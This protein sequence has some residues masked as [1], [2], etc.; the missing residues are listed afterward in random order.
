MNPSNLVATLVALLASASLA[1]AAPPADWLIEPAPFKARVTKSQDGRDLE[2]NNGLPCHSKWITVSN[3]TDQAV[4]VDRFSSEVLAVV[5]HTAEVEELSEGR[6][7]PHLYIETDMAFGGMMAAGANRRSFR[8]LADP[9]FHTQVNYEKKTP[10]LLDVG[11]D[12]G[13]AQ[14][15]APGG[16]FESFSI[17]NAPGRWSS[18][19]SI[20][21]R[22]TATSWKAISSTTAGPTRA[23]STGC[24]T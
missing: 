23:T 18:R 8:W 9:D 1:S 12:L 24:C 21:S 13:P 15:V 17:P 22:R 5:E 7:P 4:R 10:C 11:P 19:R 6:T 16:V 2:L 3:G 14:E 20:G